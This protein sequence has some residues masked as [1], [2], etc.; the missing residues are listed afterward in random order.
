MSTEVQEVCVVSNEKLTTRFESERFKQDPF[1][2]IEDQ[3]PRWSRAWFE[4]AASDPGCMVHDFEYIATVVA[5][6]AVAAVENR[7]RNGLRY[8][9]MDPHDQLI[10][11]RTMKVKD[12]QPSPCPIPVNVTK[13]AIVIDPPPG[14][15][16]ST[17]DVGTSLRDAG[18]AAHK[19]A[20]GMDKHRVGLLR[21]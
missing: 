11:R 14:N 8:Q 21:L 10:M 2:R 19:P 18:T 15:G 1:G 5:V 16:H 4:H 6:A 20:K 9:D 3:Q 13:H 12:S 7:A 17:N